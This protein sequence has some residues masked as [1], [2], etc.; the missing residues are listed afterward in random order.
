MRTL[1]E[2]DDSMK[3]LA[4][5]GLAKTNERTMEIWVDHRVLGI[6]QDDLARREGVSRN[7]INQRVKSGDEQIL[8]FLEGRTL[9][10]R[11]LY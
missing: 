1:A 9:R 5:C 7:R 8:R 4:M 10:E 11:L 6:R 3:L 2:L